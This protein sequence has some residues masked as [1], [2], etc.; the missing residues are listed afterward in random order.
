MRVHPADWILTHPNFIKANTLEREFGVLCQSCHG[1]DYTG[2]TSDVSCVDCHNTTRLH[3]CIGCH[4]GQ[5]NETGAPPLSLRDSTA[6]SAR[7]VGAHTAMVVGKSLFNG[8]DCSSCHIKPAF[9]LAPGHWAPKGIDSD[10]IAEVVF[11]GISGLD[12]ARFGAPVF[13]TL[14]G[15]CA[16][17]YCHGAFPGGNTADTVDFYGGPSEAF[18]GSCHAVDSNFATLG[19]KHF[20]HDSLGI[21]CVTCHFST[22]D[23]SNVI[24]LS[25]GRHVNG[26]IVDDVVFDP[27]VDTLGIGLFDGVSCSGMPDRTL[28]GGC[29]AN[30]EDW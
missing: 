6:T 16:N 30:K 21:Q 2:G 23:S 14:T 5:D 12:S 13:D 8:T 19:G 17:I 27:S 28:T 20:K 4:G 15:T 18:C 29:H 25:G 22:V 26:L 1:T 3:P 7:G 9:V 24:R 11:G 10:S